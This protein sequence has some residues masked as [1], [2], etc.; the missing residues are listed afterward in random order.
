MR[1]RPT[2]IVAD[3]HIGCK[4]CIRDGRTCF[5]PRTGQVPITLSGNEE[6]RKHTITSRERLT[7]TPGPSTSTYLR[8]GDS[9]ITHL[10]AR[11]HSPV[12]RHRGIHLDDVPAL[13]DATPDGN[14]VYRSRATQLRQMAYDIRG[15]WDTFDELRGN[16]NRDTGLN[17]TLEN[18][19]SW[20]TQIEALQNPHND[21]NQTHARKRKRKAVLSED[22]EEE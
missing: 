2:C 6:G 9:S 22:E 3:G 5:W 8:R 20:D 7:A 1:N 10:F 21:A 18:M 16:L 12:Q 14:T 15:Y 11:E 4:K 19:E 17:L 13:I